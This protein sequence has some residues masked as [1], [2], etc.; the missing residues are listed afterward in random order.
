MAELTTLAR[1]YARAAF[2]V[3]IAD[4]QLQPW[5]DALDM[6]AAVSCNAK[7]LALLESPGLTTKQK[8][9]ALVEVLGNISNPKFGN[10]IATL[11]DNKRLLLLPYIREHFFA[12]KAQQQKT[13][14]VSIA[15]AYPIDEELSEK[16]SEALSQKLQRQ[17]KLSTSVDQSLL[18]G[19]LIHADDTV[20]DGSVKGRLAKLA[21]AMKA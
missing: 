7:V 5:T 6:S 21:E 17:V 1:P 8:S 4:G 11:A 3:A 13:I 12:M 10:F 2:D 16:L 14:D 19:V 20:I 9:D 15:S 18:G